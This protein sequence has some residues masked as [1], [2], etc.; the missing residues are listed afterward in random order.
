MRRLPPLTTLRFF[1]AAARLLSFKRAA[2]ELHVTPTAVSHQIRQLEGLL[3]V[4]LFERRTRQVLLTPPGQQLYP[5]LRDGFD[6]FAKALEALSVKRERLAV[7]L[8]ATTAL[9]A[10]WLL[11]RVA[12]FRQAYPDVDL[13][14]HA[15]DD[16]VELAGGNVD[17]AIRYGRGNYPGLTV[18]RLFS[19]R[20]APVCS[21]WLKVAKPADLHGQTLLHAE[22]RHV[23]ERTP[24]WRRW[25]ERA[26]LDGLAMEGGVTF[27]DDSHVIQAALA[28]QGVALL[29]L[30]MV[31]DDLASGALVQPFGPALAGHDHNL[32]YPLEAAGS[33]GIAV[34]R[35]WLLGG[36]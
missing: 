23:D 2:D 1:E 17:A 22:W 33:R 7:T 14:L 6:A 32:V 26:G 19:D 5:V 20:F 25:S 8:S 11:P 29:S 10:K 21:P 18:E 16:V 3:G 24:T 31:A 27:N 30:E 15:S 13:R 4:A 28:G 36:G 12:A 9:T 34:L 35:E